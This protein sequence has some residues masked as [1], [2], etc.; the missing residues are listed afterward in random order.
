M[1]YKF[2]AQK[3]ISFVE[4][5]KYFGVSIKINLIEQVS[6]HWSILIEIVRPRDSIKFTRDSEQEIRKVRKDLV[7]ASSV[8]SR[9][10]LLFKQHVFRRTVIILIASRLEQSGPGSSVLTLMACVQVRV[11]SVNCSRV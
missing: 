9:F 2:A 5:L 1:L 4:Q 10:N 6:N 11:S 8:L 7:N 3:D